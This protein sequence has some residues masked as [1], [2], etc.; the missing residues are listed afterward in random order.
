MKSGS[1][2]QSQDELKKMSFRVNV[3]ESVRSMGYEK[4]ER[5]RK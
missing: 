4:I 1:L 3:P 5:I 2:G